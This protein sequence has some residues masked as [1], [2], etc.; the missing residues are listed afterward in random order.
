VLSASRVSARLALAAFKSPVVA[1]I[2]RVLERI[3]LDPKKL[4]P[5]TALSRLVTDLSLQRDLI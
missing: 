1:S 2:A 4:N 5:F 3:L